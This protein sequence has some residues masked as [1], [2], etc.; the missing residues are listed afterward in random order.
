V[1]NRLKV[2][3]ISGIKKQNVESNIDYQLG[4]IPCK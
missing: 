1:Q 2:K 3:S 4:Y